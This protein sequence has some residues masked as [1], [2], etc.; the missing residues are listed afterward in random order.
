[1]NT[2]SSPIF[3]EYA[4][5]LLTLLTSIR[6]QLEGAVR[7]AK[8]ESLFQD[9]RRALLSRLERE[10]DESDEIIGQMEIEVQTQLHQ[11]DKQDLQAK[12]KAHVS[13]LSRTRQEI[14]Q[15]ESTTDRDDL[16]STT[17]NPHTTLPI[18]SETSDDP[19][20]SNSPSAHAQRI[21]LMS[22][23][24]QLSQGQKRLQ[25]SHRVALETEDLGAGILRDLRGQRDVL[26]H[27]RD[28]L[29]ETD[30][31]ID[32]A[33]NT[34]GKMVRIMHQQKAVTYAIIGVL[35]FLM[36]VTA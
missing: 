31:S 7:Q 17:S 16:L 32:R 26:Q 18:T 27:A 28:G 35:V 14:K 13:S 34:I 29:Y 12:L 21:A 30:G 5:D 22:T 10:L 20:R 11:A 23:T 15:L 25:E 4:Q 36:S 33:S 1:M 2:T 6:N 19:L 24:D 8:G 9:D 3:D